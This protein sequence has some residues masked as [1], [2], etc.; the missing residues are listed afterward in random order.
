M[1]CE[2]D[3]AATHT[4]SQQLVASGVRL[5]VVGVTSETF[6]K[7]RAEARS[8]YRRRGGGLSIASRQLP[9]STQP[10][11]LN[12]MLLCHGWLSDTPGVSEDGRVSTTNRPP[13]FY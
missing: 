9:T 13:P 2:R 10:S 4:S 11:D 12:K 6:F 7:R 1:V 3:A 5:G 8:S